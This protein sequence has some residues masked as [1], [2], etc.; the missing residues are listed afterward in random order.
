LRFVLGAKTKSIID[1]PQRRG[2]AL[3]DGRFV[4]GEMILV[5]AGVT[6]NREL[7]DGLPLGSGR[8]V[9]VNDLLET[10]IPDMYAAGDLIEHRNVMYGIWP[11]AERQGKIAGA[12]M[13]GGREEYAGTLP[14]NVLKVAGI[15][16]MSAGNIDAEGRYRA[17]VEADPEKGVY[18][19]LV[20][21][22]DTLVGCILCGSTEGKKEILTAI[23]EKKP[24]Q[25]RI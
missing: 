14:S 13:A 22:G 3:E 23:Q 2:I 4:A 6:P 11:A 8:G 1:L 9:Q 24:F 5:S 10:G 16:L 19:K 20:L 25:E 18:K 12:N 21:D 15:D 7:L 17:I